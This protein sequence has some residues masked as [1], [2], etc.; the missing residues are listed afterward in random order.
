MDILDLMRRE[1]A[2]NNSGNPEFNRFLTQ[3][4]GR[5]ARRQREFF[6]GR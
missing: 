4:E 3:I 5:N 2:M 6:N 1:A